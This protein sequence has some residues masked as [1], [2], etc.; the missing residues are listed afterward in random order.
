MRRNG[1]CTNNYMINSKNLKIELRLFRVLIF[2][3]MFGGLV[4]AEQEKVTFMYQKNTRVLKEA[5]DS[6]SE[7]L[8]EAGRSKEIEV[9]I[10]NELLEYLKNLE[11]WIDLS[12]DGLES[13]TDYNIGGLARAERRSLL[14]SR[15]TE[16]ISSVLGLH[17]DLS[18]NSSLKDRLKLLS[19]ELD[20][21]ETE[22]GSEYANQT[23]GNS[24][25]NIAPLKDTPVPDQ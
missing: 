8:A 11:R 19:R 6:Y 9:Q 17:E 5:V 20:D 22:G 15:V 25:E 7:L 21:F 2:A 18:P 10:E 13:K 16:M 23:S 24:Q 1:R 3:F 4:L 12:Y 14:I